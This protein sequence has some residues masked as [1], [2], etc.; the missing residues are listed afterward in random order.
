MNPMDPTSHS[1]VLVIFPLP[2]SRY[3]IKASASTPPRH[4]SKAART[5]TTT[6]GAVRQRAP[7][8]VPP[9]PGQPT[10]HV[11]AHPPPPYNNHASNPDPCAF[12]IGPA[13][14]LEQ[15]TDDTGTTLPSKQ[16]TAPSNREMSDGKDGGSTPSQQPDATSSSPTWYHYL[17][18]PTFD[19]ADGEIALP[20]PAIATTTLPSQATVM[21]SAW[22][23]TPTTTTG[24]T[25]ASLQPRNTVDYNLSAAKSRPSKA[26]QHPPTMPPLSN[27][28]PQPPA[29][30]QL[31]SSSL[32]REHDTTMI[33]PA[34]PPY[35]PPSSPP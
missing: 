5:T 22:T 10:E 4:R 31:S 24:G 30:S 15:E 16:S 23:R 3:F 11:L 12:F 1:L 20:E 25:S 7:V 18:P 17:F 26:A 13:I 27:P 14:S 33:P 9:P 32:R 28:P 6:N 34:Q 29:L 2:Q 8:A 19:T 21:H 35:A